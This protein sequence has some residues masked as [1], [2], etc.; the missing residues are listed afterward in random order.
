ML[1]GCSVLWSCQ[2]F[3]LWLPVSNWKNFPL[4]QNQQCMSQQ[5]G[6]LLQML[7]HLGSHTDSLK[8]SV[9]CLFLPFAH[10]CRIICTYKVAIWFPTKNGVSTSWCVCVSDWKSN[11][12]NNMTVRY[13]TSCTHWNFR[14]TESFVVCN[15]ELECITHQ[16]SFSRTQMDAL[17]SISIISFLQRTLCSSSQLLALTDCCLMTMMFV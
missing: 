2:M 4:N 16:N 7:E 14:M 10:G 13:S 17:V 9:A 11:F 15:E 3:C 8:L 1:L 5:E 6:S 12:S